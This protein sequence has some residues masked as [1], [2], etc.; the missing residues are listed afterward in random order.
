MRDIPS[1]TYEGTKQVLAWPMNKDEYNKYRDWTT[2]P[3]E[4]PNEPGYLIEYLD[5]GKRNDPRHPGYISW[6]P[7]DVFDRTYKTI[8]PPGWFDRLVAEHS[9]MEDRALRLR[10]FL[11]SKN[12]PVVGSTEQRLMTTQ[13]EYMSGYIQI[14]AARIAHE[15]HKQRQQAHKEVM[16]KAMTTGEKTAPTAPDAD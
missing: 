8:D 7:A 14:L 4:G 11:A 15:R 6:T 2:P 3:D 12:A 1:A 5:G 16:V 13:S 10:K 9:G